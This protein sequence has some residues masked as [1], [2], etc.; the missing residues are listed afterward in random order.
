M[1]DFLEAGKITGTHA[2]SGEIRVEPWCDN[3]DFLCRFKH[4]YF[5][6]GEKIKII[7][8]RPHKN[9]VIMRLEG[10]NTVAEADLLRGKILYIDRHD[11]KLPEGRYFIQD[12]IG[13]EVIDADSGLDYGTVT[14]V[15]K[16]GA[17]DVYQVSKNGED[18]LMPAIPDVIAETDIE[19]G[20]LKIHRIGGLFDDED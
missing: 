6:S 20:K 18:Y 12:V 15:L 19:G 13:L 5:E 4:L 9:T 8:S 3:A 14:D 7:G 2:L 17:N 11:V 10:I 1:K 16:T